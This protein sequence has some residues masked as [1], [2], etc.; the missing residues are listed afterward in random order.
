MAAYTAKCHAPGCTNVGDCA[1]GF[2]GS[3]YNAFRKAC[4]E[5]G[6]WALRGLPDPMIPK[7]EYE[8]DEQTLIDLLEK[9]DRE[10]KYRGTKQ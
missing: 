1:R 3:H 10:K 5:N 7:F 8:G 9:E 6:S 2:C 4:I